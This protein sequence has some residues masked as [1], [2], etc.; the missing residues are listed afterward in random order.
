[1]T[2]K[3]DAMHDAQHHYCFERKIAVIVVIV[4]NVVVTMKLCVYTIMSV[5]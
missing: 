2:M 3:W 1:M 5:K 4:L